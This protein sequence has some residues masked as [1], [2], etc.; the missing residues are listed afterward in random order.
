[1]AVLSFDSLVFKP[2]WIFSTQASKSWW[3]VTSQT[4]VWMD[5]NLGSCHLPERASTMELH[6]FQAEGSH[7][8]FDTGPNSDF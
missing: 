6:V 5:H 1:M 3:P 4:S 7:S 2:S 8:D